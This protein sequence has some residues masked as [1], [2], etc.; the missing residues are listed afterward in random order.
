VCGCGWGGEKAVS[1]ISLIC[2][3][4]RVGELRKMSSRGT[5]RRHLFLMLKRRKVDSEGWGGSWVAGVA[6]MN[7][8]FASRA[9]VAADRRCN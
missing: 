1:F 2:R 8:D 5:T 7:E 4:Y 9:P 6:S 3:K